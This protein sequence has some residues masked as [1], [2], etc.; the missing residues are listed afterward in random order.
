MPGLDGAEVLR[1]LRARPGPNRDIPVLA[2]TAEAQ[3][4]GLAAP[5]GFDAVVGKPIDVEA[6]AAA[7]ST[8][9]S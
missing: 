8:A 2:F 9:I 5:E 3:S 4:D 7:L 6:L 1:R